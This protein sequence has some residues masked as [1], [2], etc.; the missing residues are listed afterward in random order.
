MNRYLLIV[1]AALA[2]VCVAG[3]AMATEPNTPA[4]THVDWLIPGYTGSVA[5]SPSDPTIWVPEQILYTA[6]SC[7]VLWIQ[8]DDYDTSTPEKAAK[9]AELIAKGTLG[10]VN[11]VPEDSTIYL[12]HT[13]R[14]QT[15]CVKP[16]DVVTSGSSDSKDCATETITTVSWSETITYTGDAAGYV[17]SAPVRVETVTTRPATAAQCPPSLAH[18]PGG[19]NW[20]WLLYGTLSLFAVGLVLKNPRR[21]FR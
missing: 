4:V 8:G 20:S 15:P 11:G 12:S 2:L 13:Y 19:E 21:L 14:Q 17:P 16:D 7:G 18:T 6:E 5:P 1:P 10:R 9:V 3:P